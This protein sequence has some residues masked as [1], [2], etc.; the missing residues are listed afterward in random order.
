MT[1]VAVT[2]AAGYLGGSVVTAAA[3]ERSLSVR[4]IVR[5]GCAWLPGE[6]VVVPDLV[7]G[8]DAAVR[9]AAAVVHL[10]GANEVVAREEPDRA[11]G[12][13]FSAARAVAEAC[14]AHSVRRLVYVSTV[15]VYGASLQPGMVVDETALPQP[16]HAYAIARLA[17]EHAVLTYSGATEVVVLRLTNGVG[18]PAHPAV[19]RWTLVAN[20]LC[21]QAARGGPIRLLTPGT[22]WRDFVA[23]ADVARAVLAA[24]SPGPLPPGVYNLGSGRSMTIRDMA[25]LVAEEARAAG[26]GDLS[27]EAPPATAPPEEPY[28][29]SVEKLA[30]AGFR[31][32]TPLRQAV[33]E[34]LAFCLSSPA[35]PAT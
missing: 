22:Q 9:G 23:L 10:A 2:G 12:E 8:A 4:P 16:R 29:V 19:D 17:C 13:A 35:T 1:V 3:E 28:T 21:R 18:A 31:A 26:L 30:R 15:H 24:A 11:V 14:S 33:A 34:T 6:V 25:E 5:S 7:S 32:V 20:D 27:I